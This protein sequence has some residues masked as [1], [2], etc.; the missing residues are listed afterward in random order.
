[1][2]QDRQVERTVLKVAR[3]ADM[4]SQFIV[5]ATIEPKVTV[6]KNGQ[7]IQIARGY[8]WEIGRASCRERVSV[9]V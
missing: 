4:Y 9:A 1:M 3:L 5:K 6:N 2:L 8:K 7:E